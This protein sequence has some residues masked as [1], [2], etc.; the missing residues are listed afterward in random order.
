MMEMADL[1]V[2]PKGQVE[3]PEIEDDE[4]DT[5]EMSGDTQ[6]DLATAMRAMAFLLDFADSLQGAQSRLYHYFSQKQGLVPVSH[7]IS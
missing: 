2:V 5:F 4:P 7:L 1:F 3:L 6:K